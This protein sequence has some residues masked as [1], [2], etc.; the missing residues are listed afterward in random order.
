[1][2]FY[3]ISEAQESGSRFARGFWLKRSP[4]VADKLSARAAT[5]RSHV[6]SDL[7]GCWQKASDITIWASP[8]CLT[9]PMIYQ[10]FPLEQMMR[11]RAH[12][13]VLFYEAQLTCALFYLL[14]ANHYIQPTLKGREIRLHLRD[15]KELVHIFLKPP[16]IL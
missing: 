11:E 1:M 12:A 9:V 15:I 3:T 5:L 6:M 10:L 8:G 4:K 14:K 16:L 13:I 7:G 2:L